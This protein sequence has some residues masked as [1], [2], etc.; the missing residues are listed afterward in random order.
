MPSAPPLNARLLTPAQYDNV[1]DDLL[2]VRDRPAKHFGGGVAAKL[3]EV[4]VEQRVN[5]ANAVAAQAVANLS[6]WSP[7]MPPAVDA[8]TCGAQLIDRLGPAA[9]RHPLSAEERAQ[10]QRLF[11]AGLAEKDFATGVDWLLT[12]LLQAPDFLYQFAKPKSREVAG[13]VVPLDSYELASRLSF[14]VWN[15]APD[16]ALYAAAATGALSDLTELGTELERMLEDARFERGVSSFYSDWLGLEGFREVA[17]DE[18]ALTSEVS[19]SLV[20]S[21]LMSAT[22]LYASAAPNFQSLFSGESYF[23]DDSLRTFY[24]LSGSG[25]ELVLTALPD[26]GR[27]GLLT[28]PALMTLLARPDRSDPIARGLFVQRALLCNDIPPPPPNLLIPEL[29]PVADGLSTRTRLEQHTERG[30]CAACHDMIDPPG[31]ALE[32]YD[33]VG[34]FRSVDHGV[35]V[36]TSGNMPEGTDVAGAFATGSELLDR[37]AASSDV[38]RCFSKRYLTF[39]L[40][41]SLQ[42]ADDCSLW[43]VS[44]SF[45]QT[46][47]LKQLI[48]AVVKTDAFRLRAAEDLGDQQ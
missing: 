14:F 18:A 5:A 33:E 39:A 23:M 24:G 34:R 2:K 16:D 1:V 45:A 41:R 32:A 10:L 12:G 7:C 4:A 11:D 8:V 44:E 9:F 38:K 30:V 47:D 42:Q 25:Q 35:P 29:S 40:A 31:F 26:E 15:S 6:A 28:H 20:R 13:Q 3:D 48:A 37:L 19:D 27:R 43:Q 46:G 22:S 36:D 17:R 21:I